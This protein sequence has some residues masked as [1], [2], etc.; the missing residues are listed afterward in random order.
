LSFTYDRA[1]AG[2][3]TFNF[4]F[5]T[6][7][8]PEIT[9][10]DINSGYG[11]AIEISINGANVAKLPNGNTLTARNLFQTQY[12]ANNAAGGNC[13][14]GMT[15]RTVVLTATGNVNPGR[16]TISIR[17]ADAKDGEY[18][19]AVFIEGSLTISNTRRA[20][21][22]LLEKK[23]PASAP[24][25]ALSQADAQQPDAVTAVLATVCIV[26]GVVALIA[27]TYMLTQKWR[28]SRAQIK[29]QMAAE[30]E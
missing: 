1:A 6:R 28:S 23:Q 19:S 29:E 8:M 4:Q 15:G 13:P 20:G 22:V 16:N 14:A 21:A 2:R 5:L 11:D 9:L 10:N 7:E 18:D 27:T 30:Q 3:A 12:Y 26:V 25:V 24:T 17:I